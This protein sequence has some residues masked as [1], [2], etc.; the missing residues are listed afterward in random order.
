MKATS[1]AVGV[2]QPR[3]QEKVI[4]EFGMPF[5]TAYFPKEHRSSSSSLFL[6]SAEKKYWLVGE[7]LQYLFRCKVQEN[8]QSSRVKFNFILNRIAPLLVCVHIHA[9][10]MYIHQI[11]NE[12]NN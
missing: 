3:C 6:P 8:L 9:Y 5:V 1:D 2:K 4:F 7:C 10:M 11:I 12:R